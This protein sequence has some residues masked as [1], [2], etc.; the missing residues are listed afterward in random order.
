M[1]HVHYA[2]S[3]NKFAT[4]RCP[5]ASDSWYGV[6]P[7]SFNI[8]TSAPRSSNSPTIL[9]RP[10]RAERC[11]G[12]Q[13]S[14]FLALTFAPWSRSTRET[15]GSTQTYFAS[16]LPLPILRSSERHRGSPGLLPT[17][18][19]SSNMCPLRLYP[20]PVRARTLPRQLS[21]PLRRY[22]TRPSS[23]RPHLSQGH[24]EL[25]PMQQSAAS[26][27]HLGLTCTRPGSLLPRFCHCPVPNLMLFYCRR[28]ERRHPR[29]AEVTILQPPGGHPAMLCVME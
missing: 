6:W 25:C 2:R 28:C 11:S 29:R 20:R 12:V 14:C 21:L 18:V 17:L 23:C 3:R 9:S 16:L 4:F 13:W 1:F 8:C 10:S 26:H 24:T 22:A 5:N 7:S 27:G 19:V 15:L